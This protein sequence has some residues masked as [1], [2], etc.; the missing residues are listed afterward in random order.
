MG[1]TLDL[2]QLSD[3]ERSFLAM[4][5]DLGRRLALANPQLDDPLRGAGVVLIDELELHLHP[6]W[7][8][9]IIHNLTTTFPR[10]QFH[11]DDPLTAGRGVRRARSGPS[12]SS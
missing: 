6:I 2:S 8:R 10:C 11:R 7:Q 9:Q 5:C 4:T 3:G 1:E 12:L